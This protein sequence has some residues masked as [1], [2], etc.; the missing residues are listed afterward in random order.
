M[1]EIKAAADEKDALKPL[2]E[3]GFKTLRSFR[4]EVQFASGNRAQFEVQ[5]NRSNFLPL[6]AS[7]TPLNDSEEKLAFY[8]SYVDATAVNLDEA[9]FQEL[10]AYFG[11]SSK[12]VFNSQRSYQLK[13]FLP[14]MMQALA[15]RRGLNS[16]IDCFSAAYARFVDLSTV[17]LITRASSDLGFDDVQRFEPLFVMDGRNPNAAVERVKSLKFGD[18]IVYPGHVTTIVTPDVLWEKANTGTTS[19]RLIDA[20]TV[21]K[22]WKGE[23]DD[24][25]GSVVRVYRPRPNLKLPKLDTIELFHPRFGKYIEKAV[26]VPLRELPDGTYDVVRPAAPAP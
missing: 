26:V 7:G 17:H 20:A 13:D 16:R 14:P 4:S 9:T 15:N 11:S 18:L 25:E 2:A 22:F 21:L 3:Y 23:V 6:E 5:L 8:Q 12:M 19:F 24:T 10:T 1:E